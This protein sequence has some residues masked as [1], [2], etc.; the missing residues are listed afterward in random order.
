MK[1]YHISPSKNR[2]AILKNGLIP[3]AE[4]RGIYANNP[5][6]ERIYLFVDLDTADDALMN[7]LGDIYEEESVDYYEVNVSLERLFIDDELMG[8]FYT[9]R[10]IFP[11][12][13]KFI[14]TEI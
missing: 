9:T 5:T 14:K 8:S 13:I 3:K 12:D 10:K 7:W 11:K 1:L 6:E 2:K 4:K